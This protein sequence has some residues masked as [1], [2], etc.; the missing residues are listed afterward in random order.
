MEDNSHIWA[1]APPTTLAYLDSIQKR[2]IR[3]IGDESI[4]SS[5]A[6]L[7]HR[8]NVGALTL[9]YKYFVG[10]DTCSQEIKS[11]LP[12][13]KIFSRPT[14]QSVNSHAYFLDINKSSTNYFENSFIVRTSKIWNLLP[15][16]VFPKVGDIH[17]YN[18]QKFKINVNN[19]IKK[20]SQYPSLLSY[21]PTPQ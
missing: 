6:P 3:L 17:T 10:N 14:R 8:R 5:L 20:L 4:T 19:T 11:I 15:S 21:F 9:L 16:E 2:A 7:G 12:E 1:G 13:L 18:L